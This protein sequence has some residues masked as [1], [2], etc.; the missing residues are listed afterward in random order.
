ME[1]LKW[2]CVNKLK[3][4]SLILYIMSILEARSSIPGYK[5]SLPTQQNQMQN[6]MQNPMQNQVFQQQ[7]MQQGPPMQTQLQGTQRIPV[8]QN[9]AMQSQAT[10]N[11]A[12]Q[13]QATQNQAMQGQAMQSQATQNQATQNQATQNQDP[14]EDISKTLQIH[15][16][17]LNTLYNSFTNIKPTDNTDLINRLSSLEKNV[18]DLNELKR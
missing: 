17:K 1:K 16:Q 9:Q 8:R 15:E 13:N 12:T 4:K 3:R 2:K 5:Y 6:P 10:Q 14:K 18:N 11:Q 7:A